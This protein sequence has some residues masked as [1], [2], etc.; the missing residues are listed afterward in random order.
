MFKSGEEEARVDLIA[1]YNDL[2]GG[3]GELGVGLLSQV[4]SE[5]IVIALR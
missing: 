3:C 4:T 2:E 5:R 1:L